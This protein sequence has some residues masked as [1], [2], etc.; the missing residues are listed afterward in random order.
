MHCAWPQCVRVHAC[1]LLRDIR[2]LGSLNC[3]SIQQKGYVLLIIYLD[4]YR[5]YLDHQ[6]GRADLAVHPHVSRL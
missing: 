6:Q 5:I 3:L 2:R 4:A 1:P